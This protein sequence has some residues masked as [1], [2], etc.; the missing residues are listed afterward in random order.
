[1][2]NANGSEDWR[3]LCELASKEMDSGKLLE[4][5][6]KINCALE[7]HNQRSK[8]GKIEIGTVILPRMSTTTDENPPFPT[9]LLLKSR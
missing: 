9:A 3:V 5:A 7:E 4:L 6:E 2:K 8:Y 1:M